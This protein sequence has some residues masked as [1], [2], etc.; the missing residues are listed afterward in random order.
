[1]GLTEVTIGH[2]PDADDAFMFYALTQGIVSSPHLKIEH[3]IQS[4]QLLNEDARNGK[5]EMS[6][7]SFG[8]FPSVSEKYS[9]MSC[10]ACM[11]FK[12][13][14]M[15]LARQARQ[16]QDL[17]NVKIAV[18]GKQ[19][20]AYLVLQIVL[21]NAETVVLPFDQIVPAIESGEVQAGLVIS[22]AQLTHER[23]GL[24]K[25]IDLGEWWYEET[26]LPLP[27]GGNVFRKDLAPE[28]KSEL[29]HVFR[30]S[31]RYALAHRE[32]AVRFAMKYARSMDVAEALD[33]IG[34]YVNEFTV[35]YGEMGRLAV[36]TL[37]R[38]AFESGALKQPVVC[39]FETA[40]VI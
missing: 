6:A 4:I 15:I 10:G 25:V 17:K 2:T 5:Y 28:T 31:I 24:A 9:L 19:T 18:P 29:T 38:K 23:L 36:E 33:F 39:E 27:L 22:E 34:R 7:L 35:D 30:E 21:P 1:M 26:K 16:M 8:A 12:T 40:T 20:T 3:A 11:G 37:Y 13:G 14:P 32:E